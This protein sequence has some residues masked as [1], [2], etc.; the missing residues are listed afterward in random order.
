MIMKKI[1]LVEDEEL[2][3]HMTLIGLKNAGFEV[4][5]FS[6]SESFLTSFVSGSGFDLYIFDIMLPG[7]TGTG[8]LKKLRDEGD[9]TPAIM[10]TAKG[11]I[12][13]KSDAFIRGADDYIVKP[14]NMDELILRVKAV[15]KRSQS[16]RAIPSS[17]KILIRGFSIDLET[18]NAETNLGIVKLSEK[19]I[20]LLK[21]F[22]QNRGVII[23]RA[24]ILEEI[25]GMDVFPTPR[26]V[27]NFILKFRK[28]FE[29]RPGEPKI[30][31]SVR[32]RG[33][34]FSG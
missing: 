24:D 30:F 17:K 21:Y 33:Y 19:E 23:S 29:I 13:Y 16:E 5:E 22:I 10:L 31:L 4:D 14:F 27:D 25:W 12:K 1:A 11:S 20:K 32:N 28:L 34:I 3:R 7:L 6:D 15:I 26:T 18:G 9:K 2:I 8:L